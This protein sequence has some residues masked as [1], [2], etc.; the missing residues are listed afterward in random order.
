MS[1]TSG[2][3][4]LPRLPDPVAA[5]LAD[6][7]EGMGTEVRAWQ[8]HGGELVPSFPRELTDPPAPGRPRLRVEAPGAPPLHLEVAGHDPGAP[9]TKVLERVVVRSYDWAQKIASCNVELSERHE[10]IGL[11]YSIS[12]TLGSLLHLEEAAR[13]IL[14]EVSRVLGAKR[15]SLWV[16][17]PEEKLLRLAASSGGAP[18]RE[19]VRLD[20]RSSITARAFND[21][22]PVLATGDQV[23]DAE[24]A[25]AA[26]KDET[27]LSV[28]VS[29]APR[30]AEAKSGKPRI[31]GVVNL[32]GRRRR[33]GFTTSDQR[34]LA[35]IASQIGAALEN[36]RLI[37]ES[38]AR[39]RASKEMALA[40]DLQKKLLPPVPPLA[41]VEA[42]ARV[43]PAESVGGDLYQVFPLSRGRV[44]VMI[45]DV[46]GHGFPAALI[47]A[48]VMSAAAIYAKAGASPSDVL[49]HVDR[50]I[51]HELE[52]TE[53]YLSLC[54]CVLSP[55]EAQITYSN[56]GHPHA[57]VVASS[58]SHWRLFA[59]DPPMGIDGPPY[60]ESTASWTPGEDL[61]LLFTDGLSDT[62][63]RLHRRSGEQ[64]VLN[65][66]S[67]ARER[68]VPEILARLFELADRAI[69]SM[70]SDDRTA[71]LLRML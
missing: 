8:E 65:T 20:D 60:G 16:Y 23:A 9:A 33:G 3:A 19:S 54:Y 66:V 13:H 68:P 18:Q 12:E 22:R 30:T 24:H 67:A 6:F 39:E 35:A 5:V 48:L 31:V 59:T 2:P 38:M 15:G 37:R 70:P 62:L 28:P 21:G 10:E 4:S 36:H 49:E 1:L 25:G 40:H 44:G 29:Y 41:G 46:S 58:G 26:D 42:A 50:A 55:D 7:G 53:M 71:L 43:Q 64:L 34:L 11:L 56:A 57:F 47:M 32:I 63:A 61:L 14:D 69:P 17:R 45:G 51:G 52:S 27:W